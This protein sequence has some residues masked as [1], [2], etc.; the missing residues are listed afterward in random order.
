MEEDLLGDADRGFIWL[1][2]R[3]RHP[4]AES[5]VDRSQL[6]R[7]RLALL[8]HR[9]EADGLEFRQQG[10]GVRADAR[11][12][13]HR[14]RPL[15]FP[16]RDRSR[17]GRLHDRHIVERHCEEGPAHAKHPKRAPI[18]VQLAVDPGG[19][20]P[21]TS[22]PAPEEDARGIG[23]MEDD[24]SRRS[25]GH[26]VD[27]RPGRQSMPESHPSATFIESDAGPCAHVPDALASPVRTGRLRGQVAGL[28]PCLRR[29]FPIA[30]EKPRRT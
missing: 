21:S 29:A 7:A 16:L 25:I 27:L 26:G 15:S 9:R 8:A 2:P 23:R 18:L 5:R 28:T 17:G 10:S 24:D 11:L 4:L 13:E 12:G 14:D 22:A 30:L 1:S 3:D 20:R 6:R 19:R